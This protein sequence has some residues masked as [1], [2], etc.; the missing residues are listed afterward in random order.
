MPQRVRT[1]ISPLSLHINVVQF[2]YAGEKHAFWQTSV[3]GFNI[4]TSQEAKLCTCLYRNFTVYTMCFEHSCINL[5]VCAKGHGD[6][7]GKRSSTVGMCRLGVSRG[8]FWTPDTIF[9][10]PAFGFCAAKWRSRG[11]WMSRRFLKVKSHMVQR[12]AM[13]N[14][15]RSVFS[16]YL[17]HKAPTSTPPPPWPHSMNFPSTT[18]VSMQCCS[19]YFV[20][21]FHTILHRTKGVASAL[22]TVEEEYCTHLANWWK[23]STWPV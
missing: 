5:Y 17:C 13:L 3:Q 4:C 18:E 15:G 19:I 8:L 23:V 1:C 14:L 21:C 16:I 2:R 7:I 10:W 9:F 12:S 11:F 20:Y 6:Y 22:A